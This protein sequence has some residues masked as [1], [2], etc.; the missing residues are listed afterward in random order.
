MIILLFGREVTEAARWLFIG[1]QSR[2]PWMNETNVDKWGKGHG[3]STCHH[4]KLILKGAESIMGK[5]KPS[6][7]DL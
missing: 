1:L 4:Q 3:G 5:V 2:S 7:N 6:A